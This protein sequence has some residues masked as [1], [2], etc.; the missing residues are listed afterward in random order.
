M[1]NVF[2]QPIRGML[3]SLGVNKISKT[4]GKLPIDEG[5]SNEELVAKL[6]MLADGM[7]EEL[8]GQKMHDEKTPLD[9][10]EQSPASPVIENKKDQAYRLQTKTEDNLDSLAQTSAPLSNPSD[11]DTN[12]DPLA[13]MAAKIACAIEEKLSSADHEKLAG[14]AERLATSMGSK[15]VSTIKENPVKS[16]A[17]TFLGGTAIGGGLGFLAGHKDKKTELKDSNKTN[18][19]H[20]FNLGAQI[21]GKMA[22][23]RLI[24]QMRLH[25]SMEGDG[26]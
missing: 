25:N 20:I 5:M 4:A 17:A 14:G 23:M 13:R 16:V 15:L 21:G 6:G 7:P 18:E 19:A 24:E 22:E 12:Q 9:N 26:K 8:A 1:E 2:L 3:D 11:L 10:I